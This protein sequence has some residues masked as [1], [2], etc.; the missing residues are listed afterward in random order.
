VTSQPIDG[1]NV[2][3]GNNMPCKT[4]SIGS[5]KI[6]IHHSIVR[7][8]SNVR[9]V[10]DLKK[11][12]ISLGTLDSYGY[13]FLAEGGVLRVSK[14]SLVVMKGKNMNNLYILQ[15]ST[16]IGDAAM[17]MSGDPD[18]DTT[19]LWHMR[20]GHMSERGLHVLSK[21]GLLCGQKKGKLDFCEHCVFGKQHRVSFGT[22]VHKTKDTLDYIHSDVWS[23]SQV[24]SKGG[25]SYLLILI[26]DYSRKV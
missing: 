14:G 2:L 18:L 23:P 15:G 8:L 26:D 17:S 11:N 1:G 7:T 10:P 24:P 25:A 22:S 9:H 20:L 19:R 13:K 12:L 4:I 3:M 16:V 5:I 21:Q 6:R